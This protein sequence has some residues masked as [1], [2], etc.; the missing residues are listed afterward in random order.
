MA[1]TLIGHPDRIEPL[2]NFLRIIAQDK[3]TV[4][5][6]GPVGSG[7]KRTIQFLIENGA[8][9]QDPVFFIE[10]LHFS[11]EVWNRALTELGESGTLVLEGLQRLPLAVQSRLKDWLIGKRP[12]GAENQTRPRGWKVIGTTTEAQSTFDELVFQFPMHIQLPSLNEVLEDIPYHLKFFLKEEP[13]RYLRYFFLLK[14]THHQWPGNLRELEHYLGQAMAYYHSM[15]L[16]PGFGGGEEVFGE[17]R[18]RYYQDVLKGEWWYYPYRFQS[19]F[20]ENLPAILNRTDF[21]KQLIEQNLVIPLLREEAGFLVLD[22]QDPEFESKAIRIYDL[23]QEYLKKN[24]S[25]G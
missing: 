6:S 25:T 17:K 23:F 13:I 11:E 2:Q 8:H 4:L 1:S 20:T 5:L 9:A 16:V 10:G 3:E 21:R 14:T 22:L 19:G 18:L 24:N 7:K 12:L 15:A